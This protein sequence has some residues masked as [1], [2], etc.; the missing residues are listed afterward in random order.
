MPR[1]EMGELTVGQQVVVVRS[2]NGQSGRKPEERCIRARIAKV[3]RVW[4]ELEPADLASGQLG[5]QTWRM[6]RDT[7]D[8]ATKF[9]GNNARFLT[10]EQYYWEED[11]RWGQQVLAARGIALTISSPWRGREAELAKLILKGEER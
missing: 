9:P 1:P 11:Q 6:R 8:E 7:Q 3:S 4:I 5:Y 2:P 10:L